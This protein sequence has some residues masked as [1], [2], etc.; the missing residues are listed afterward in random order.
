MDTMIYDVTSADSAYEWVLKLLDI[1]GY[2]L[3]DK[4][5]LEFDSNNDAFIE[6]QLK[7]IK[8]WDIE[9][10]DFVVIHFT[11]N[12]D[13]CMNIKQNGIMNLQRVV[14]E[15]T[16]FKRFLSS[17]RIQF[18]IDNALM[19]VGDA[20]YNVDYDYYKN[21]P[22]YPMTEQDKNLKE[23]ARKLYYDPQINGFFYVEDV[24]RYGSNIHERPEFLYNIS[25]LSAQLKDLEKK[26]G[27]TCVGYEIKYKAKFNE[28]AWYSFYENKDEFYE[29]MQIDRIN[30][31]KELLSNALN[32]AF[33]KRS[34]YWYAYMKLET[35]IPNEQIL[36]YTKI[37]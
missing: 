2:E 20:K 24:K 19:V 6:S 8:M 9:N 11:T 23:I 30:L 26:W 29:D 25:Q 12:K 33:S 7:R 14:T 31:K 3:I 4:Y 17:N 15:D 28:F 5:I 34:S 35:T 37:N 27:N 1:S 10:T 16:E 36:K 32:I 13:E 22:S 18:D 21:I